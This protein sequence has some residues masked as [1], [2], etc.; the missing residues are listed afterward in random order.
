MGATTILNFTMK[1]TGCTLYRASKQGS[2]L[3]NIQLLLIL[4]LTQAQSITIF[5]TM[6]DK[7]SNNIEDLEAKVAELIKLTSRLSGENSSLKDQL[8]Q[9]KSD[10]ASLFEQKEHVRSQVENMIAR[11]KTMETT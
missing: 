6:N 5:S 2:G 4:L 10:R 8:Q 1:S 9:I 3:N 7:T 11:L